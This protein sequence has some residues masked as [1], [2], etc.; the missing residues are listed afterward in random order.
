MVERLKIMLVFFLDVWNGEEVDAYGC[1]AN[2]GGT[3]DAGTGDIVGVGGKAL[4]VEDIIASFH[5]ALVV[6]IDV[7]DI[8]PSAYQVASHRHLLDAMASLAIMLLFAFESLLI[9]FI[10]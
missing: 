1:M 5:Y 9:E 4:L 10:Q 2:R 6:D 7:G 3:A 8:N